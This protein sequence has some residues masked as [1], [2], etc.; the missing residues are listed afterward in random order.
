MHLTR[1]VVSITTDASGN[2]TGYTDIA[3][4]FVQSIRYVADGTTPYDNTA[5]FTITAEQSGVAI[6]T[7]TNATASATY[8]PR[9]ATVS[10][11]NA[12]L[13][14]AAGGTAVATPVPVVNERVKIVIAQGGNVKTGAFHVYVGG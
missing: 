6:L 4:G 9:D 2:G 13:L 12:A 11:A 1:H 14:Y 8:Y 7:V 10:V 5:D 3:D